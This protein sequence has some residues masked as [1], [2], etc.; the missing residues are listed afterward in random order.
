[1]YM[2]SV[3]LCTHLFCVSGVSRREQSYIINLYHYVIQTVSLSL[4][5]RKTDKTCHTA[6]QCI[7]LQH[8]TRLCNRNSLSLS[9]RK[10][11]KTCQ[12]ESLSYTHTHTHTRTHKHKRTTRTRTHARTHTYAHIHTHIHTQACPQAHTH[13]HTHTYTSIPAITRTH[14]LTHFLEALH[15]DSRSNKGLHGHYR[16]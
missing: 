15:I 1:M 2:H 9:D 4:S 6:T 11:D 5:D 13:T 3:S 12:G 10:T 14:T 8:V 7:T 16:P